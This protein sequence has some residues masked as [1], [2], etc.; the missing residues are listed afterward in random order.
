M[1]NYEIKNS[2]VSEDQKM[3]KIQEDLKNKE[4]NNELKKLKDKLAMVESSRNE[5]A[6]EL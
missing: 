6:K 1:M 4:H 3:H 2:N 5:R